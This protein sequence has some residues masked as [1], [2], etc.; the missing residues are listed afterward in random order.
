[1]PPIAVLIVLVT[2][3]L[4]FAYGIPSATQ[5]LEER[6]QAVTL[7]QA[8]ATADAITGEHPEDWQELLDLPQIDAG[9][10][11]SANDRGSGVLRR[12]LDLYAT[13]PGAEIR[14]VNREGEVVAHEGQELFSPPSEMLDKAASGERFFE[15]TEDLNVAVVPLLYGGQLAGG[16]VFVTRQWGAVVYEPLLRSGV[17]AAGVATVLGGG[18]ALLLAAFLSRRVERLARGARFIEGGDLS[19]RIEPDFHDELGELAKAFNAMAAK[20][21]DSFARLEERVAERTAQLEGERARLEA[22]LQQMPSGVVIAEVPSGRFILTNEQIDWIWRRP[23]RPATNIEEYR[24]YKLFH[25]DGR[26]YKLEERP[27][28]RSIK[29]GE[30][31]TGEETGFLRGDGTRGTMRVSSAPIRDRGGRIVA[32]VVVLDDVTEQKRAEE[33]LRASEE[34]YRIF[35]ETASDAIV[36]IDEDSRILFVNGATERIFGHTRKEMLGQQLT[37][38]MPECLRETHLAALKRYADTG[39]RTVDW[40]SVQLRGLHKSGKEIPL[41]I[42]FGDFAKGGK[43]FFFGFIR[44]ITERKRAEENIRRLNEELEQRVE[45]RTAQLEQER[46][47]LDAILDSLT[48]GV[49]AVDA[50]EC[51]VFANPAGRAMLGMSEESAELPSPWEDFDL[52]E[53]VT[54]CSLTQEGGEASVRGGKSFL[55]IKLEH[56]PKLG[57]G[58]KDGVLIVT[59]DLSEGR[60]L[61]EAQQKFLA[62]AAHELR[63]PL[64][65]ITLA[66]ELLVTKG[67]DDPVARRR[68]LEHI[69]TGAERLRRLSDSLLKLARVGWGRRE[70]ELEPVDL[71]CIVHAAAEIAKPLAESAGLELA[72]EGAGVRVVADP[73]L[74]EEALLL[75]I[76][77]SI[78]HSDPSQKVR[79]RITGASVTVEDQAGGIAEE[80]LPHLFERF[81]SPR[82]DS[83]GGFGLGLPICKEL[84][85]R[86]G[87]ELSVRSE[88]G[89]GTSV[90]IELPE[91]DPDA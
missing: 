35:A 6:T 39:E 17:E 53:A 48:E 49:L 10:Q 4:V 67:D 7:A 23:F 88:S 30:V 40:R 55:R 13:G 75:P 56:V 29:S 27:L 81:Y 21:Q 50:S 78:Q 57:D 43:R 60:R 9:E 66:A 62:N 44:D 37:M 89:V 26:P 34:R 59:Q 77:N 42:S 41:E 52:R 22:V 38:L 51:V 70:P 5:R 46:A 28:V 83:S 12:S 31:V 8:A 72:V 68:F 14:V 19:Y 15:R 45:E 58:G 3:A 25:P 69:L 86:M 32:G 74:L 18:L 47:T 63:T 91:A 80:D 20:L 1:M 33:E 76:A 65:A 73:A 85:E 11:A 71:S 16:V 54:S 90:R 82:K 79:L 24:Q 36:M 2:I 61:E 64:S 84:V 87:G